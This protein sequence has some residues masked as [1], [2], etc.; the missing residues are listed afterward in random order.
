MLPT[1]TVRRHRTCRGRR[2]RGLPRTRRRGGGS[3][4]AADLSSAAQS[5]PSRFAELL[6]RDRWHT[7]PLPRSYHTKLARWLGW[8]AAH[9]RQPVEQERS[10]YVIDLVASALTDALAA[11]PPTASDALRRYKERVGAVAKHASAFVH[12]IRKAVNLPAPHVQKFAAIAI[13]LLTLFG[14]SSRGFAHAFA[15]R[16]GVSDHDLGLACTTVPHLNIFKYGIRLLNTLLRKDAKAC[17]EVYGEVVTRACLSACLPST[18]DAVA[19]S[20][21]KAASDA[22]PATASLR[23]ALRTTKV[24]PKAWS[25]M[26]EMLATP[27]FGLAG[28][29][30]GV[31]VGGAISA[32]W[33]LGL[34]SGLVA[35]DEVLGKYHKATAKASVSLETLLLDAFVGNAEQ[36]SWSQKSAHGKPRCLQWCLNDPNGPQLT[37]DRSLYARRSWMSMSTKGAHGFVRLDERWINSGA[38][39]KALIEYFKDTT[40]VRDEDRRAMQ[41]KL[42]EWGEVGLK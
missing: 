33:F 2:R 41:T 14:E 12:S 1:R 10:L 16:V 24:K 37:I 8:G 17:G 39:A 19:L 13:R 20:L 18:T 5:D 22:A 21:L 28:M 32:Y 6:K 26:L 4:F 25:D 42:L 36:S 15:Q 30:A 7:L 31:M 9:K 29:M 40:R 3:R 27:V 38:V 34:F 11:P 23:D 35:K